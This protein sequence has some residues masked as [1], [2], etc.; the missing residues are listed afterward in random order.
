MAQKSSSSLECDT[1]SA[2]IVTA[3]GE[4]LRAH[5]DSSG[6]AGGNPTLSA[7]MLAMGDAGSR[8]NLREC[9]R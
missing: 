9:V 1:A 3:G 8:V 2:A 4:L 7:V 6:G 5:S